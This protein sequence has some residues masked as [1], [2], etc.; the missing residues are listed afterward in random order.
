MSSAA[1]PKTVRRRASSA[2]GPRRGRHAATA[3][4][5]VRDERRA[6]MDA[7]ACIVPM[8]GAMA[9]EHVEVVL[10][11]L[12]C[13][14]RSV[15]RIAN[16]HVTGR[17]VDSPLLAGPGNDEGMAILGKAMLDADPSGH[18]PVFPYPTRS[19]DG[20]PLTSGTVLFRD[21]LGQAFAG[22]CVNVDAT[23]I[24]AARAVLA[25]LLPH[26]A[27]PDEPP[28]VEAPEMQGLMR[29]IIDASVRRFGKP[30]RMMDKAEKTAAV[31]MML[32]RGL[33]IVKGGVEKAA[34][35]LGVTRFTIYNYLDA[36]KEERAADATPS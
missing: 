15:V 14:E 12:T 29:E 19:R 32:E 31:E 11:D 10:H 24:E 13:P 2:R 20:R 22:L 34:A 5:T 35:A 6:V 36:L 18:V 7:L 4:A 26:A 23:G 16:G 21:S 8:M 28:K 1:P 17:G 33:F 3:P 27:V 30:V 9:G 25:R